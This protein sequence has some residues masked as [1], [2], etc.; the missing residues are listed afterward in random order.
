MTGASGLPGNTTGR[1]PMS[2]LA[3]TRSLNRIGFLTR[4]LLQSALDLLF[5]PRCIECNRVGS[6]F[7]ASCQ[8]RLPLLSPV[9]PGPPLAELRST[10][11]YRGGIAKAI[12]TLK[13]RGQWAYADILGRRLAEEFARSNWQPAFVTAVPMHEKRLRERGF[14]HSERL[15]GAMGIAAGLA[16]Q[17]AAIWRLRNTPQQVGLDYRQRQENVAGAF[18]ANPG[19][20]AG[21][22]VLIVD[23]V[24]T[25]G[26]TLR[27]CGN[28]LIAAGAVA[29]WALT[30]ARAVQD[31]DS[32]V[33]V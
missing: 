33:S 15:A 4:R 29:V 21:K 22:S 2:D 28:A 18:Q 8:S 24:Y 32:L 25:T 27:E 9:Y 10:A 1:N 3:S 7:C 23:D 26:A 16:F 13:Y 14:N 5:P 30:V 17:P 12:K 6:L 31:R 11:D 19:L 20:A